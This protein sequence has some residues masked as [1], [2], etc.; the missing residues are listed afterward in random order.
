MNYKKGHIFIVPTL[1]ELLQSGCT[2]RTPG[3]YSHPDVP[4][5]YLTIGVA[6]S[7]GGRVLTIKDGPNIDGFYSAVETNNW[8]FH[9]E[10]CQQI[11]A[12][13]WHGAQSTSPACE[14]SSKPN[15]TCTPGMT[16]VDGWTICK[17]CGKNLKKFGML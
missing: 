11:V 14:S 6:L 15:H 3:K 17:H 5:G 16:P 9:V 8:L 12:A 10:F 1:D 13:V 4:G 2:E 7:C